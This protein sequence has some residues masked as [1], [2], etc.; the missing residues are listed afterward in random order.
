MG[1]G[2]LQELEEK[3]LAAGALQAKILKTSGAFHTKLMESARQTLLR[4]LEA[5]KPKMKPPRCQVYLNR[6]G[7]P[8]G[9]QSSVD[10]IVQQLG[11]QLVNPV[12]WSQSMEKAVE[13]GCTTF[14]ECGPSKQLK[15]MLK[16]INPKSAEKTTNIAV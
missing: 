5:A 16:R 4:E 1:E 3:A 2:A 12:L 8:V 14:Y 9:P 7:A 10:E 13:D 15:A 11:E 6:T